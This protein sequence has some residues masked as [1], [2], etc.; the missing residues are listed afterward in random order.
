MTL[1][2]DGINESVKLPN[3]P[4]QSKA[5]G[6][7]IRGDTSTHEAMMAEGSAALLEAMMAAPRARK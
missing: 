6:D 7:G 3:P 5:I 1:W 2:G 4:R